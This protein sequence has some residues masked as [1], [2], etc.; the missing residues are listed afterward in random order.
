MAHR[1]WMKAGV[2]MQRVHRM[3]GI[4]FAPLLGLGL[5]VL[6]ASGI[7]LWWTLRRDRGAGVALIALGCAIAGIL[8][9]WMRLG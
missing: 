9:V 1:T 3:R 4:G 8:A 2:W 6:G 5:L 7:Y